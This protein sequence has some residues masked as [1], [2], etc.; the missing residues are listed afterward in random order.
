MPSVELA[1]L[2]ERMQNESTIRLDTVFIQ[3]DYL[4]CRELE[5]RQEVYEGKLKTEHGE[6]SIGVR[7]QLSKRYHTC[8]EN[9]YRLFISN[10]IPWQTVNSP[11]IFKM[12]DV[13][14]VRIDF[15]SGEAK[16]VSGGYNAS[17][18]KYSGYVRRGLVPVWNVRLL[19]IKSEDFPLAALDKVNYEYVFD[20]G[21]EGA[22]HGYLTDYGSADI[23]AVRREKSSLIVTSPAPKGLVWD[24]YKIIKRKE[25]TT[26]YFPHDLMNNA[27]DDS[28]AARMIA[29]YGTVIKTNAELHRL[30]A[31]YDVSEYIELDSVSVVS[32]IVMGETYE[33]NNFLKDEIRDL[34]VGKSLLLKFKPLKSDSYILRDVMSF[35]VS[36]VQVVYP[37]FHCAGVLI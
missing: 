16:G 29:Y 18:G 33:V 7:L 28:F 14:L 2:R 19:S 15:G 22:E 27:P 13:N 24:M 31:A 4:V 3:A 37:E 26:D 21:D 30:L 11:Y 25:Y 34:S 1:G 36:Q 23:S 10:N 12:F 17:F 32:G 20:L 5:G 6:F 9:L 35:L 8:L